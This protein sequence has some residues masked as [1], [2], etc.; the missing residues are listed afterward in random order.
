MHRRKR[1]DVHIIYNRL[2]RAGRYCWRDRNRQH[3]KHHI[4]IRAKAGTVIPAGY[5]V[6]TPGGLQCIITVFEFIVGYIVNI[7]LGW[8]VWDYSGLPFNLY[9]Q[10]CLYYFLLWMPLSMA[11]I[12]L[13]DWIRYIVYINVK[14]WSPWTQIQKRER[15]HYK[16]I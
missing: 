4:T 10:I 3:G 2:N 14:K 6:S 9:G 8:Q 1:D 5:L 12:V 13:D 15:P 16:L 7:H 11:G